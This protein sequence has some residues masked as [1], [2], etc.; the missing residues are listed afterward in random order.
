M[1]MN[2]AEKFVEQAREIEVMHRRLN[3]MY[4]DC[5]G[6]DTDL[7]KHRQSLVAAKRALRV[8]RMGAQAEAIKHLA[9]DNRQ[10]AMH[11]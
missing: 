11:L 10:I 8:V 3:E 5:L 7:A 9:E 1:S 6:R 2:N 4:D